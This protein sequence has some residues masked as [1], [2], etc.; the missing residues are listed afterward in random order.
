[1]LSREAARMHP[2]VIDQMI[3]FGTPVVGGPSYT[4]LAFHCSE[5]HLAEIRAVIEAR[6]Q[7]PIEVPVTAIW[8]RNDGVVNPEACI[9]RC[10]PGRREHRSDRHTRRAGLRTERVGH[11]V[12]PP[13]SACCSIRRRSSTCG[14]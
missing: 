13:R 8:S 12:G 2:D 10:S 7:T 1:M 3:T 5:E 6:E 9:D 11:R 14:Q 4:L